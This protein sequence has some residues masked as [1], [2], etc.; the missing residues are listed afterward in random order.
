MKSD[1]GEPR[2]LMQDHWLLATEGRLNE[3]SCL[4]GQVLANFFRKGPNILGVVG[5]EEKSWVLCKYY[6]TTPKPQI[7]IKVVL[8][9]FKIYYYYY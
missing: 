9:K 4:V 7:F 2:D 8:I 6:K 5:Q 1:A 3:A